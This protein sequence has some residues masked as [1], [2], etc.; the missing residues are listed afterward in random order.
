MHPNSSPPST[1][2]KISITTLDLANLSSVKSYVE[3]QLVPLGVTSLDT[4]ILNA[5]MN[6]LVYNRTVD[7]FEE[8]M[9]VNYLANVLLS[10]LLLPLLKTSGKLK[11]KKTANLTFVGS[12]LHKQAGR[13]SMGYNNKEE[14]GMLAYLLSEEPFQGGMVARKLNGMQYNNSKLAIALFV[15]HLSTMQSVVK[16]EEVVVNHTC[17]GFIK[18]TNGDARLNGPVKAVM[19]L[20]RGVR[21]KSVLK[22]GEGVVK[23]AMMGEESHGRFVNEGLLEGEEVEVEAVRDE[24]MRVRLWEETVEVLKGVCPELKI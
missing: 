15:K 1:P 13:G 4:V 3:T 9:Q 19:W 17:P 16:K 7:G 22:G 18:G 21:G 8:V 2:P 12:V 24:E 10:F 6:N 23:A 20:L 5:G 11:E 14:K